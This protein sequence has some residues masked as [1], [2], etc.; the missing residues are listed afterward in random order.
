M[1]HCIQATIT[2]PP[3]KQRQVKAG[4]HGGHIS[5]NDG[6]LLLRQVNNRL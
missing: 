4:F 1:T 2:F 5:S 6:V 3:L